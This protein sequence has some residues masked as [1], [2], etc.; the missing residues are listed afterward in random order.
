MNRRTYIT[1]F[2]RISILWMVWLGVACNTQSE[3][4]DYMSN[5][6]VEVM[7][8]ASGDGASTRTEIDPDDLSYVRWSIGDQ[9]AIWATNTTT[10]QK[11]LAGDMFQLKYYGTEFNNAEFASTISE[12]DDAYRYIYSGFYPYTTTTSG[13]TVSYSIPSIQSGQYDGSCDFRM[14]DDV[15]GMA[16]SESTMGGAKLIF[17]P[18]THAFRITIPE[19]CNNLGVPIQKL[20]FEMPK[21]VAGDFTIDASGLGSTPTMVRGSDNITLDLGEETIDA[22]DGKYVWLFMN[23]T[24][25]VT[26]TIEVTAQGTNLKYTEVYEIELTDH[27]FL[28]GRITP[29]N[30]KIPVAYGLRTTIQ[31]TMGDNYLGEDI[32][33]VTFTAANSNAHFLETDSNTVTFEA[34]NLNTYTV[35]YVADLYGEYFANQPI[36]VTYG[37][38]HA[39][40]PTTIAYSDINVDDM[41]YITLDVPY[42]FSEDFRA[43]SAFS[44]DDNNATGA[45]LADGAANWGSG[46]GSSLSGYGLS[47]WSGYRVGGQAKTAV[48]VCGREQAGKKYDGRMDSAPFANIR[49]NVSVDLDVTFYYSGGEKEYKADDWLFFIYYYGDP[50]F[51]Y[52]WTTQEGNLS[53]DDSFDNGVSPWIS[54]GTTGSY[55][56]VGT[57]ANFTI[58]SGTSLT[59]L[60][61]KAGCDKDSATIQNGNYWLYIDNIKVKIAQ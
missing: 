15:E 57:K 52:G 9:V 61:W 47:G 23:E 5:R 8:S 41:T 27:D 49:P 55:T 38:E 14:A 59:R 4:F 13:T 45:N 25:D 20:I 31:L 16:L 21:N 28:A 44:I 51:T 6:A 56:S 17:R 60:S 42:L 50:L 53:D 19:G 18:L 48:R 34:N 33:S 26:G 22:G 11:A 30:L 29:I 43:I 37:S 1:L 12:M 10:N 3:E 40:V 7:L 46:D 35:S 2:S 36:T 24:T 39:L 58:S 32:T 54:Q